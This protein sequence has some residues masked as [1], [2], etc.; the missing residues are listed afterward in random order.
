ML[1][2]YFY[3][4]AVFASLLQLLFFFLA[5]YGG[6]AAIRNSVRRGFYKAE[7]YACIDGPTIHQVL[8]IINSLIAVV[9][10]ASLVFCLA[11]LLFKRWDKRRKYGAY[12]F[13]ISLSVL[14]GGLLLRVI[15]C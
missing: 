12:S 3:N 8:D 11:T 10:F 13:L 5:P 1:G 4:F 2:K 15:G 6:I 7:A 9:Y 14:A